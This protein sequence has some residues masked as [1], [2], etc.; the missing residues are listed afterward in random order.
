MID[1][2]TDLY[3]QWIDIYNQLIA[4]YIPSDHFIQVT[5]ISGIVIL[6]SAYILL[7][8]KWKWH[9]M[10]ITS[11]YRSK[12]PCRRK[13]NGFCVL[14]GQ[15][16]TDFRKRRV[17]WKKNWHGML[18]LRQLDIWILLCGIG[19]FCMLEIVSDMGRSPDKRSHEWTGLLF[20]VALIA[21]R[22]PRVNLILEISVQVFIRI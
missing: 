8:R 7:S 19:N 22:F 9:G 2:L 18:L 6:L 14:L 21:N 16:R 11:K 10:N 20:Q 12:T 5:L 4:E 15:M 13:E 1:R 17:E 3:N